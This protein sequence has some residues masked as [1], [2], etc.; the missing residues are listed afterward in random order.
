MIYHVSC[1]LLMSKKGT[2]PST[3]F[4]Y[5][6]NPLLVPRDY[7]LVVK[8]GNDGFAC[9]VKGNNRVLAPSEVT[10]GYAERKQL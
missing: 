1:T 3:A 5:W 4:W 6:A 7:S 2:H 10:Q 9:Y 8:S